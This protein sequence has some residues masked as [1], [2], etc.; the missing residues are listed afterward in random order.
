M[1]IRQIIDF[2]IPADLRVKLK[3]SKKIDYFLVLD[4]EKKKKSETRKWW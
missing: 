1:R 3:E 4:R 2:A